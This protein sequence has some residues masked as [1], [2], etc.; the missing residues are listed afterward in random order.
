MN[1]SDKIV[2]NFLLIKSYSI[3]ADQ[4]VDIDQFQEP[5]FLSIINVQAYKENK[6]TRLD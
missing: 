2:I 4:Y 3:V 1:S 5:L 6:N